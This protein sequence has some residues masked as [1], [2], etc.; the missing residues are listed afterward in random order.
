MS[1]EVGVLVGVDGRP[2]YWHTPKGA[3]AVELPDSPTLWDAIWQHRKVLHGFAH[4]HPGHGVPS[5]SGTDLTTFAAIEAALGTRLTW[6]ILTQDE[7]ITLH[8]DSTMGKYV[9]TA[10]GSIGGRWV[11]T[12]R[13]MSSSGEDV[14]TIE[15]KQ[16]ADMLRQQLMRLAPEKRI[17]VLG[18]M[19]FCLVCG[20]DLR[21][22]DSSSVRICYCTRDE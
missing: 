2:R 9:T 13:E 3:S 20:E 11:R 21:S 15:N 5:P 10:A 8:W 1:I 7:A 6:W 12:L 22:A 18:G 19:N 4:T 17:Q 16:L 14:E